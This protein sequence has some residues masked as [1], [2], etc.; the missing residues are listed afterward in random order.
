[1]MAGML[2][3]DNGKYHLNML[4]IVGLLIRQRKLVSCLFGEIMHFVQY[5]WIWPPCAVRNT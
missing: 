2:R 1:M 5:G 4:L 3:R